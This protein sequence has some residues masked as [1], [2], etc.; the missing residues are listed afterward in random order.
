MSDTREAFENNVDPK[1]CALCIKLEDKAECPDVEEHM[2][3]MTEEEYEPGEQPHIY[4][5]GCGRCMYQ[6]FLLK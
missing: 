6:Y 3:V 1:F 2:D 4:G 5:C